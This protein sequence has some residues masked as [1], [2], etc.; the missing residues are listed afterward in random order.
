MTLGIVVVVGSGWPFG[1]HTSVTQRV[2]LQP[3][4][5]VVSRPGFGCLCPDHVEIA[6]CSQGSLASGA[7]HVPGGDQ[8][9]TRTSRCDVRETILGPQMLRFQSLQILLPA[10]LGVLLQLGDGIG[11][12]SQRRWQGLGLVG[13]VTTSIGR[14]KHRFGK[15]RQEDRVPFQALGSMRAQE[16]DGVIVRDEGLFQPDAVPLLGVNM[17]QEALETGVIARPDESRALSHEL[18]ELARVPSACDKLLLDAKNP[19]HA[20]GQIQDGLGRVAD[21]PLH[22]LGELPEPIQSSLG[23]ALGRIEDGFEEAWG[24]ARI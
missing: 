4:E 17:G 23:D 13:P 19:D 5:V 11:V 7:P 20:L 2:L 15:A 16:F 10:C 22:L 21:E 8:P 9:G 3:R 12:T 18:R 14:R 1:R 6:G 24:K